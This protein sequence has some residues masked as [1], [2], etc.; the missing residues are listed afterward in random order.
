MRRCGACP[1][2]LAPHRFT[3]KR[4]LARSL[5][6]RTS[7]LSGFRI[8]FPAFPHSFRHDPPQSVQDR[9]ERGNDARETAARA[10]AGYVLMQNV[11]S[12]CGRQA[13]RTA[14]AMGC[15][16]RRSKGNRAGAQAG[17]GKRQAACG[18]P[19]Q[20]RLTMSGHQLKNST[21]PVFKLYI[22]PAILI[23][24]FFSSSAS[25]GLFERMFATVISTFLRA[26]ASTKS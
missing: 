14:V 2:K 15:A 8:R 6:V 11:V 25:T 23:A 10:D 1:R 16:E 13:A 21:A 22:E 18:R 24:P 17:T 5:P 3:G 19:A 26:T 20:A 7:G 9:N 4:Y 12:L